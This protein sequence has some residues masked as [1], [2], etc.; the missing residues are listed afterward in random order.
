MG[1]PHCP[2]C[3]VL[4]FV[5]A[6]GAKGMLVWSAICINSTET[7][8]GISI[9]FFAINGKLTIAV[10]IIEIWNNKEKSKF[11]GTDY[12][13]LYG[14]DISATLVKPDPD[15]IPIISSTLP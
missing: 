11:W 5:S 1:F 14:S 6:L 2:I 3:E 9:G 8:G 7:K 13:S 15:S 12:L 4:A 10:V